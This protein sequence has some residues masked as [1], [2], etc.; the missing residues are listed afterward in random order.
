VV[1]NPNWKDETLELAEGINSQILNEDKGAQETLEISRSDNPAQHIIHRGAG[2]G[3]ICIT[4]H[5]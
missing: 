2:E 4:H 3:F 1:S 5:F